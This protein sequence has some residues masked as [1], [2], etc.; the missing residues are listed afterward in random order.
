M[1][2]KF[3]QLFFLSLLFFISCSPPVVYSSKATPPSRTNSLPIQKNAHWLNKW[4]AL[5][6]GKPTVFRIVQLGDSHTAGDFFT[7]TI[8]HRLQKRFGNAGIGWVYPAKVNGQR[9]AKMSYRNDHWQTF[10]SRRQER[11]D[12]PL[13][14]IIAANDGAG[15]V[16]LASRNSTNNRQKI[17]LMFKAMVVGSPLTIV[18]GSGYKNTIEPD[19]RLN[20]GQWQYQTITAQ[21]PFSYHCAEDD[22]WQLGYLNIENQRPGVTVSAFGINGAQLK[23]V[24]KWRRS[25]PQDLSRTQADLVILSYGT[26]E[27]FDD[28]L[29]ADKTRRLW[30]DTIR[31]IKRALPQAGILIVG[32]PES[33]VNQ[34]GDCG[35]RPPALDTIQAIQRDIANAE[36]ILYWSWEKAMGGRCSM[37]KQIRLDLARRDGVHFSAAGYETAA[38]QLADYLIALSGATNRHNPSK[39]QQVKGYFSP[40]LP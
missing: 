38:N 16:T 27:A 13:G 2:V 17:T 21:L 24:L 37:K 26:N 34:D 5:A 20:R 6:K 14:G 4:K 9:Q 39:S 40:R 23:E 25:W 35:V 22:R 12:F 19:D 11:R 31:R 28:R 32:A 1:T 36:G 8:R 3:N 15:K 7:N 10:T 33:L 29:D 30:R 18:D